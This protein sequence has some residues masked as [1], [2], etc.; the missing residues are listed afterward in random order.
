VAGG[1]VPTLAMQL[2][3]FDHE[4]QGARRLGLDP[5]K[6]LGRAQG[7]QL[8][9]EPTLGDVATGHLGDADEVVDDQRAERPTPVGALEQ[10][11]RGA[12]SAPVDAREPGA[13]GMGR[14]ATNHGCRRRGRRGY[15]AAL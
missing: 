5:R 12:R 9:L 13:Y 14:A 2:E 3:R 15:D 11:P 1:D 6:L 4:A 7:G 10:D 8:R